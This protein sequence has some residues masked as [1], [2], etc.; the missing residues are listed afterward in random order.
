MAKFKNRMK[1]PVFL[2]SFFGLI[3]DFRPV[4]D[5][6]YLY[7][8][9]FNP[10]DDSIIAYTKFSVSFERA[11]ERFTVKIRMGGESFFYRVLDFFFPLPRKPWDIAANCEMMINQF[12]RVRHACRRLIARLCYARQTAHFLYRGGRPARPKAGLL[13]ARALFPAGEQPL[14]LSGSDPGAPVLS[15]RP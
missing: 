10:K 1:D 12:E 4:L 13:P 9:V 2:Y 3:I 5:D 8:I 14:L 6:K 11:A 7:C 15:R